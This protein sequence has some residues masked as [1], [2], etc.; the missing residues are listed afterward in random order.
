MNKWIFLNHFKSIPPYEIK[1]WNM[2][3]MFHKK[4]LCNDYFGQLDYSQKQNNQGFL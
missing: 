4:V 3:S 1:K 2:E